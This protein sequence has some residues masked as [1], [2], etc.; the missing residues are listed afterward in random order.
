MKRNEWDG[1]F[2][3]EVL[4][5]D[6]AS[7]ARLGKLTTPHGVIFT[8]AFMPVGTYGAV[9]GITPDE[10]KY[11]GADIVLSNALHLEFRPGS[12]IV[13]ELGGLHRLM[14]WNG[15]ILTDSG[16]FQTFSLA[17]LMKH[18]EEGIAVQSPVDGSSHSLSPEKIVQIQRRLGTDFIMP[19]DVCAPGKSDR[20]GIVKALE[21]T[22]RWAKRSKETYLETSPVHGKP[23]AIFGIVQGGVFEDLRGMAIESLLETGFFAYAIGGLAV[24]ESKED[25]WKTVDYCTSRLPGDRIRYMMGSGT[26]EDIRRAVSLGIDLFD[27]VIP[28]RNGRKGSVFV[29]QG[30][31]NLR[32]AAFK[33]DREPIETGCNCYACRTNSDGSPKL[34][35]GAIRHL[36]VSKDPLG[37]RLGA[38]HNLTHYLN[39]MKSIQSDIE[40]QSTAAA[41]STK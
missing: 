24:G 23:Q 22:A 21:T 17:A 28:T 34:S 26:P 20:D 33:T 35:R 39:L 40:K 4:F 41:D 36:L 2:S 11:A 10:L 25:T 12:D 19:L 9:K 5:E 32:N 38:L 15:P 7:K 14:G 31:L 16:G 1:G 37:A 13:A 18:G 8:P 3:F 27:C 6:P 30:R 29:S